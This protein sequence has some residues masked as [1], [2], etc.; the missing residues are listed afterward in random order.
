MSNV[1]LPG[2]ITVNVPTDPDGTAQQSVAVPTSGGCVYIP[3]SSDSLHIATPAPAPG[4]TPASSS[5]GATVET[6]YTLDFLNRLGPPLITPG[7][8][9]FGVQF[10]GK[11]YPLITLKDREALVRAMLADPVALH[12]MEAQ[13]GGATNV[14]IDGNTVSVTYGSQ[15]AAGAPQAD[16]YH[17]PA[18]VAQGGHPPRPLGPPVHVPPQPAPVGSPEVSEDYSFLDDPN[19]SI[20]DKLFLFMQ[21]FE[22]KMNKELEN[23]MK[24]YRAKQNAS[25]TPGATNGGNGVESMLGGVAG[26]VVG[27]LLNAVVPGVG[28]MFGQAISSAVQAGAGSSG[29]ASSGNSLDDQQAALNSEQQEF[30]QIGQIEKKVQEMVT[31]LS[32]ALKA[33]HDTSMTVINNIR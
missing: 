25:S 18:P 28:S 20:E 22:D 3:P 5:G 9:G 31:M 8:G 23:D 14:T 7:P 1:S 21:K 10:N 30:E 2:G 15:A 32:N 26:A 29:G 6:M 17:D 13:L 11:G 12:Q 19:M 27:T 24:A 4:A 16:G 33:M